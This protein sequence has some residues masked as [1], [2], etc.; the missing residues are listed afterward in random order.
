MFVYFRVFLQS[1]RLIFEEKFNAFKIFTKKKIIS[2]L[3]LFSKS[4]YTNNSSFKNWFYC[5]NVS[6]NFSHKT[7]NKFFVRYS[8]HFWWIRT[9]PFAI[10]LLISCFLLKFFPSKKNSYWTNLFSLDI[11]TF[12][13]YNIYFHEP[14]VFALP[15]KFSSG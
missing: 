4:V 2:Y 7:S 15:K 12:K 1:A 9:W 3:I 8:W 5:L 11:Y 14:V 10:F 6:I 13:I